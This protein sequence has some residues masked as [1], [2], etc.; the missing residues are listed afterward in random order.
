[1]ERLKSIGRGA[2]KV[3]K[4]AVIGTSVAATAAITAGGIYTKIGSEQRTTEVDHFNDFLNG[5][6]APD[7]RITLYGASMSHQELKQFVFDTFFH[8]ANPKVKCGPEDTDEV[9]KMIDS[10]V[11]KKATVET[12]NLLS[13]FSDDAKCGRSFS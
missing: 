11:S 7:E 3:A 4:Y 5:K 13:E 2:L 9:D 8:C 6:A 12:E 10:F 1:M